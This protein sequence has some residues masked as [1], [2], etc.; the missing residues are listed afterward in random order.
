MCDY[1]KEVEVRNLRWGEKEKWEDYWE[2][3]YMFVF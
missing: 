1:N 2:R 3:N